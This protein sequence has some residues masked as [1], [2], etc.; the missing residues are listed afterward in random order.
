VAVSGSA[1]AVGSSL[2]SGVW[3]ASPAEKEDGGAGGSLTS[4]FREQP[5]IDT[6]KTAINTKTPVFLILRPAFHT[7]I[8]QP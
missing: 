4:T 3:E 8:L 6:A 1:V 5:I 2:G 7:P